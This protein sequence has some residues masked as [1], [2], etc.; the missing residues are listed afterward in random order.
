MM[1]YFE[2]SLKTIE[3]ELFKKIYL[4]IIDQQFILNISNFTMSVS[5]SSFNHLKKKFTSVFNFCI[6]EFTYVDDE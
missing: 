4:H 5:S 3:N 2:N 6:D 1:K